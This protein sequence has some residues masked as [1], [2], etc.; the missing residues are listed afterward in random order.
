MLRSRYL[1]RPQQCDHGE[2]YQRAWHQTQ[3][4][5]RFAEI[6]RELRPEA[7]LA[8]AVA[9]VHNRVRCSGVADEP[10]MFDL[11]GHVRH[12]FSADYARNVLRDWAHVRVDEAS[13]HYARDEPNAFLY[14]VARAV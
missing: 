11:D 12:F 5:P 1:A 14:V 3:P 6:R 4:D 13:G 2:C 8:F 10:D 9:S 7:P